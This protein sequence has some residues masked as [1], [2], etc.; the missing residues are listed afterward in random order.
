MNLP[1]YI[2][3]IGEQAAATLFG[4]SLSRIRSWRYGRRQVMPNDARTIIEKTGGKVGWE[5][6]YPPT[7]KVETKAAPKT[8][9]KARRRSGRARP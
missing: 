3:T 8:K 6:I 9:A 1:E 4:V 7:P 2:A 5:E